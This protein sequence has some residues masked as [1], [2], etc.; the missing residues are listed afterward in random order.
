MVRI[1]WAV[2]AGVLLGMGVVACGA[3]QAQDFP[4]RKPGLWQV[5]MT[6]P[7]GPMPAQQMKMCIDAATDVEMQKL[8]TN[9]TQGMC[10]KPD[11]R[12]S[13]ST[14]TVNA[15]CKMGETQTSTH[16]VTKFTGDSAYHTDVTTKFDPPMSGRGEQ[17]MAQDGK[18][19]G[20]CPADMQP[21]DVQMGNG[22]KMNIKQMMGGR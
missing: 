15:S 14:V 4:Q 19:T 7:G 6:M 9:A 1:T 20:P 5:E 21:G 12:R 22:M 13:G 3:A 16:A 2:G 10:T 17:V 8:G 18:W 11:I